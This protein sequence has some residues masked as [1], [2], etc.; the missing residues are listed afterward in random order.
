M[1]DVGEEVSKEKSIKK[2]RAESRNRGG[3]RE[4]YE[5]EDIER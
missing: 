5:D 4:G 2:E 3:R 1:C